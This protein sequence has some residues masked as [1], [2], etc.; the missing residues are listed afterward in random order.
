MDN[1]TFGLSMT[2]VGMG[3]TLVSLL[4]LTFIIWILKKI[5]SPAAQPEGDQK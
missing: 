4:V 2:V 3:G 1:L 5:F